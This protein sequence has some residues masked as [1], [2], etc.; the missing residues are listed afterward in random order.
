MHAG[1]LVTLAGLAVVA[2]AAAGAG[3]VCL[4]PPAPATLVHA[5]VTQVI[6]GDTIRV[7]RGLGASERV[8]LI[9]IDAPEVYAGAHLDEV[10]RRTHRSRAEILTQGRRARAFARRHLA[11]RTVGLEFD[12]ERLDRHGRTLAYVWLPDGTMFNVRIVRE[13][14][15]QALTVPPNV[16]YAALF[17]ACQREARAAMRGLWAR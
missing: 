6:D 17:V 3:P 2:I 9:G 5:A 16:R 1:S 8:R 14:Y 13:G 15:A 7:R 12:V 4:D 10:G 11:G